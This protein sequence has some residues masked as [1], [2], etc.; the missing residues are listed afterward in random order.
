MF[1]NGTLHLSW[2]EFQTN[3]AESFQRV[4]QN[5]EYCDVTLACEGVQL[6]RA[7]R[8]V[9]S[10]GSTFFINILQKTQ[11]HNHPLLYIRY[12]Y[13]LVQFV[14]TCQSILNIYKIMS[15]SSGELTKRKLILYWTSSTVARP[16]L[17]K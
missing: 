17:N 4:K 3:V 13:K 14:H 11:E 2:N 10:V 9:L 6:I 5:Q 7:H 16:E 15:L 1:P 8:V 12:I